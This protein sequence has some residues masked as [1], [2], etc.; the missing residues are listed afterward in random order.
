MIA[1]WILAVVWDY[2]S[3]PNTTAATVAIE[4]RRKDT[5]RQTKN[6]LE[7]LPDILP[8]T[9]E[10]ELLKDRIGTSCWRHGSEAMPEGGT[11][12]AVQR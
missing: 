10:L 4:L 1:T 9:F 7:G 8:G 6:A 2:R 3:Q 11:E 12:D 5:M